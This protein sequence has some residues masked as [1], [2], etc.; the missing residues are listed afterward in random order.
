[1]GVDGPSTTRP[2]WAENSESRVTGGHRSGGRRTATAGGRDGFEPL[3]DAFW[4][5]RTGQ[6]ID[7]FGHRWAVDQHLRG[8]PYDEVVRLAAA[9]LGGGDGDA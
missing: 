7:P 6:F 2:A 4:G 9:A 1:M 5:D 8:V 3:R